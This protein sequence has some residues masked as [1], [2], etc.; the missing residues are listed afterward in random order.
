MGERNLHTP[1]PTYSILFANECS[2]PFRPVYLRERL[3]GFIKSF[4]RNTIFLRLFEWAEP[5]LRI[6]DPV[7]G[8]L[9]T[10]VLVDPY[11]C[12][13]SRVFSVHHELKTGAIYSARTAFEEAH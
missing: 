5:S 1:S 2:R 6:D 4:P 8:L 3:E 7:A 12:L 13:S 10:V 11:D 9:Q